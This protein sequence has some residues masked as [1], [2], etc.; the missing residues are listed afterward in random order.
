[1]KNMKSLSIL[2]VMYVIAGCTVTKQKEYPPV[3]DSG[4]TLV[5]AERDA[6]W[7]AAHEGGGQSGSDFF[8]RVNGYLENATVCYDPYSLTGY[9]LMQDGMDHA[10]R[11]LN[12]T[13]CSTNKIGTVTLQ[14]D[15]SFLHLRTGPS[16]KY[17]LVLIDP[18]D[19]DSFVKQVKGS[20]VTVILPCNTGDRD[21]PVWAEIQVSYHNRT[22]VG[23]SSQRYITIAGIR[24]LQPGQQFTVEVDNY[25]SELT[26]S[27]SD[28]SVASIDPVSGTITAHR[29][30]LVL[31]TV[32]S[33][34]GLEDSCL[35]MVD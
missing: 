18:R 4:Y 21:N 17:D 34:A 14:D 12:I 35:I 19:E 27:S 31:I 20:L 30:G 22:V 9:T 26:W 25:T 10:Q 15:D 1:M 5:E 33:Q 24:H 28:D 8:R 32:R 11:Y 16:T 2:I 3:D 13:N 7:V 6:V 29:S 23:Y